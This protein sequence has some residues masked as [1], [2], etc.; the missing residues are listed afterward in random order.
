MRLDTAEL[1]GDRAWIAGIE[2]H[3]VDH[4]SRR[5]H[6]DV[7]QPV[8]DLAVGEFQQDIE[9]AVELGERELFDETTGCNRPLDAAAEFEETPSGE[10]THVFL[11]QTRE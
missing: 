9:R 8:G 1:I 6:H 2:H 7:T 11:R 3:E 4:R 5:R 10:L